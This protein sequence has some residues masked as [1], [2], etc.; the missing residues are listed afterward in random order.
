MDLDIQRVDHTLAMLGGE[1]VIA[2]RYVLTDPVS[3][4]EI[5]QL[6]YVDDSGEI[7]IISHGVLDSPADEDGFPTE[8]HELFF[9]RKPGSP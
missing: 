8:L 9:T 7:P 5:Q 2:N 1:A 4:A 3:G 6:W